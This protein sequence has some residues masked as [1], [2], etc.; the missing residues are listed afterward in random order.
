M[1]KL[2]KNPVEMRKKIS[3]NVNKS[4]L[5]LVED[6]AKLTKTNN[7]LVIE[8]LLVKGISPLFQQFKHSWTAMSIETKD[9][10]KKEQLK[11]LLEELK[12]I[13]EKK[14]VVALLNN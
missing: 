11:N 5:N 1:D 10:K 9:E 8:A 7:T 3:L 12:N 4:I 13:S 2:I 14:E 6:I